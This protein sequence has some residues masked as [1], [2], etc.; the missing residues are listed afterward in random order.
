MK[1]TYLFRPRSKMVSQTTMGKQ[2]MTEEVVPPARKKRLGVSQRFFVMQFVLFSVL[3]VILG[4]IQAVTTVQRTRTEYG[5]RALVISQM[6]A[7]VPTVIDYLNHPEERI[8]INPLMNHLREQVHADFLVVGSKLGI[9]YAHPF[10][11]EIS[12]HIMSGD[13]KED[14]LAETHPIETG[15]GNLGNFIWGKAS[16]HDPDG[17]VIGMVSTGFLL[18]TV[19]SVAWRVVWDILPWYG[20][21]V[22]FALISSVVVS[23]RIRREMFNLEPEQIASLV[24]QHR[25]VL[26]ALNEGVMV[27][28]SQ[29]Q[30]MLANGRAAGLLELHRQSGPLSE[31]WPEWHDLHQQHE[32]DFE[33]VSLNFGPRPLLVSRFGLPEDQAVVVIRDREE[34]MNLAEELTQVK[35]YATMLRAQTH[36]FMNRLHTIGGLIQLDKPELALEVVQ[37]EVK[38]HQQI[39]EI[40]QDIEIPQVAALLIGKH[41]RARELGIPFEIDPLSN[42]QANWDRTTRDVL[43]LTLGN[44]IENAFDAAL[45]NHRAPIRVQIAEDPEGL[46]L[47]VQDG[48]SGIP[49]DLLERIF[50]QGFSTRGEGRGY[51]LH[52]IQQQLK[53]VHGHIECFRQDHRTT[54]RVSIPR[55]EGQHG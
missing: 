23:R 43:V 14:V 7:N 52:L 18:P 16:V 4:S 46:Q 40:M 36:E 34:A 54:F 41:E 22:V 9:R 32:G 6:V 8:A 44:L 11:P 17:Y 39:R 29:G 38:Q 25:L 45:E 51:G 12:E 42:L 47:E 10:P 19:Q 5:E 31:W 55:Q 37:G 1:T 50:D 24:Y 15:E 2:L 13:S 28:S 3:T 49:E 26:G 21:S 27:I 33:G 53:L 30:V 35:Q 20:L 48:G